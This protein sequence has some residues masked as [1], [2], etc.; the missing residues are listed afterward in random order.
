MGEKGTLFNWNGKWRRVPVDFVFPLNMGLQ[1][2]FTKYFYG[3]PNKKIGPFRNIQGP[4]LN[5]KYNKYGRDHVHAFKRLM[6]FLRRLYYRFGQFKCIFLM[7]SMRSS[8]LDR[9]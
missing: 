7:F 8:D 1:S 2:A 3:D 5:V 6:D 9:S 4:D